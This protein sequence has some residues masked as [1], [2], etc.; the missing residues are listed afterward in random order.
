MTQVRLTQEAEMAEDQVK[1]FM[2]HVDRDP[3]MQHELKDSIS[4][5][6]SLAAKHGYH[7][8]LQEMYAYVHK[9]TGMKHP[10]KYADPDT[11]CIII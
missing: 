8:T 4:S 6:R 3:K 7:F 9:K 10:T 2:E 11:C 1:A 5:V